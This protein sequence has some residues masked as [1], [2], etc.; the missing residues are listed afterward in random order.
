MSKA[1]WLPE[2]AP[3]G[4]LSVVEILDTGYLQ[5]K[6]SDKDEHY[7][8]DPAKFLELV[9]T[10]H[11]HKEQRPEANTSELEIPVHGIYVDHTG[12]SHIRPGPAEANHAHINRDAMDLT[13]MSAD[14]VDKLISQHFHQTWASPYRDEIEKGEHRELQGLCNLNVFGPPEPCHPAL[15]PLAA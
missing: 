13:K 10:D 4:N 5:V 9:R 14:D 7:E 8:M 2:D 15:K 12:R 1:N 3:E 6:F 11:L